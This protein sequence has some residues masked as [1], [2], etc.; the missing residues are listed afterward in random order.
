MASSK[1]Q[2][3]LEPDSGSGCHCT[4]LRKASR[5]ISQLYDA[6]LASG[7]LKTTQRAILAEIGRSEPLTVGTLAAA[8]VMDS[9][10]LAHTLKPLE[11]EGWV[12]TS[13]DETD[14]RNRLII[15]TRSGR[16]KL[17]DTEQRWERAQQ[18]FEAVMGRAEVEALRIVLGVL[19]SDDFAAA[20]KAAGGP[21]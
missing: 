13:V 11:R 21:W 19:A 15:L 10:A 6:A 7:E 4:V 5:R 16:A 3:A 12:A 14:R 20:F 18:A 9:G 8:L 2:A 1:R 17:A